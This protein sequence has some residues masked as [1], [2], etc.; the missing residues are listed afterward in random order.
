MH[1]RMQLTVGRRHVPDVPQAVRWRRLRPLR[2][3]PRELPRV[4]GW[5]RRR[6]R[7]DRKVLDKVHRGAMYG[8]RFGADRGC[9]PMHMQR[10]HDAETLMP[11]V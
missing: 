8:V 4:H 11:C 6:Y 5:V 3:R 7:R 1:L 10:M 9:V 2:C